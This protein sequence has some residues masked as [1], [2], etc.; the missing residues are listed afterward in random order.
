MTVQTTRVGSRTYI[1]GQ[2]YAAREM[3]RAA[4]A[5]WDADRKAWW[6]GDHER[7]LA[8]A[9][10]VA[11]MSDKERLEL[12]RENILG[13]ASY[14]GHSYYVVGRG[15]NAKGDW[16]RLMFRDGSRVFFKDACE[17]RIEKLYEYTRTLRD[18]QRYAQA[19]RGKEMREERECSACARYCTCGTGTFCSHHHDGCE[20]CGAER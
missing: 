19:M 5:H 8:L 14:N 11:Q 17:V 12:D 10:K 3:L 15:S 9:A 7:A 13:R 2:T 18:L 4:G 20:Q 1:E 16:V 6:L